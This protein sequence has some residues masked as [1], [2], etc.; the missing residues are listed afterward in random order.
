MKNKLAVILIL[1]LVLVAC[2]QNGLG[3]WNATKNFFMTPINAVQ[4]LWT[5]ARYSSME[6]KTEFDE[7]K[8]EELRYCHSADGKP[9][10]G[11][12][13][14]EMENLSE[15]VMALSCQCQP[16]GD[17]PLDVCSCERQC[18][19]NF[20]IFK[21]PNHKPIKNMTRMMNGLAFR[22]GN[23]PG[24]HEETQGYCWGHANITSQ[25]NRLAFFKPGTKAPHD[26]KSSDP[27][28]ENRA[29]SYYKDLIDKITSNEAT[30]I[31][32]INN[33]FELSSHP[34]LQSYI[35]DKVA[36]TWAKNAMSWQGLGTA[37]SSKEQLTY[38]Y[39]LLIEDVKKRIDMNMQP[40]IVFTSRDSP[41]MTHATLISHYET[42]PDGGIILCVRDNNYS[43]QGAANCANPMK[44]VP[45]KGLVY[46]GSLT[47]KGEMIGGME[48]GGI[49]L[50]HNENADAL[51]QAESLRK[52]C[53][54]ER[55]CP[56]K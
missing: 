47:Q 54:S 22:N 52:K 15:K 13:L 33:L 25:F 14:A 19:E 28:E 37:L 3:A 46:N 40:T 4:S 12:E 38:T 17:C 51:T 10:V 36:N 23:T 50:A 35:G 26:L 9:I 56:N 43:E 48:V 6:G 49:R 1:L 41:F 16:W 21:R 18:P 44:I 20:K 8:A 30:D 31:P 42:S 53:S 24:Q 11:K 34:A 45:G 2:D 55:D 27:T 32:G 39:E 29:I 7:Q 5:N